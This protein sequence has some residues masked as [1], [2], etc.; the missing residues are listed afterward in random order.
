MP[1]K[2]KAKQL[3]AGR[4]HYANNSERIKARVAQNNKLIRLRNKAYVDGL[5]ANTPCEDCGFI[6]PPY[7]MQFDHVLEG[8]RNAVANLVREGVSIQVIQTEID[9]CELVC[10]NCHAERT[11]SRK[12]ESEEFFNEA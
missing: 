10:S 7:V 3:E 9:K 5:K 8:K 4:K 2:D 6:Y 12:V 11:H 1:F